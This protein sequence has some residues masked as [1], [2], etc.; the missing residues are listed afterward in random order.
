M[1]S[2]FRFGSFFALGLLF[3]ACE[4]KTLDD[5]AAKTQAISDVSAFQFMPDGGGNCLLVHRVPYMQNCDKAK[6]G[7]AHW[8][9]IA[10][11]QGIDGHLTD[12]V[13]DVKTA[14]RDGFVTI[15][16]A[17]RGLSKFESLRCGFFGDDTTTL[18]LE[19]RIIVMGVFCGDPTSQAGAI[20]T[21]S[22]DLKGFYSALELAQ[23][24][25][26]AWSLPDKLK[27]AGMCSD[28]TSLLPQSIE[29]LSCLTKTEE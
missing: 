23:P 24:S 5:T 12:T 3:S 25:T 13:S 4:N 26:T 28:S 14:Q 6:L 7:D 15:T 20:R 21:F 9:L 17:G 29:A 22:P 10:N 16:F 8:A 11:L 18:M 27:R 19:V 1:F 2:L